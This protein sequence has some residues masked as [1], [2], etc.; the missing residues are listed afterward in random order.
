MASA[1]S[2]VLTTVQDVRDAVPDSFPN[3]PA[4]LSAQLLGLDA[5]CVLADL[6]RVQKCSKKG[7]AF[8]SVASDQL[9]NSSRPC[10]GPSGWT[11]SST[12]KPW[13][14]TVELVGLYS[15]IESEAP[16]FLYRW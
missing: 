3:N 12:L 14:K 1:L 4:Q 6:F 11:K 7:G 13:L 10:C 2:K 16:G 15:R 5:T 8:V 9:R